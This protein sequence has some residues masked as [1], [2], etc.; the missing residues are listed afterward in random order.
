MLGR[1][2]GVSHTTVEHALKHLEEL[3]VLAPVERGKKRQVNLAKLRKISTMQGRQS[4]RILFLTADPSSNP[5][6]TTRVFY[7]T[8]LELCE[9]EG[10][11]LDYIEIPSKLPEL[12]ALLI[13]LQPR[14]IILCRAAPGIAKV[15]RSLGI[16]AIGL[17]WPFPGIPAFFTDYSTLVIQ[18]FEQA[19]AVGHRRIASP[20][21]NMDPA[22][23]ERVAK[24]MGKHFSEDKGF[25]KRRYNFPSFHGETTEDF[26]AALRELFRYTPPS[27]LIL[28]DLSHYISVVTFLM[29]RRLRVPDDISLIIL[30][31][32]PILDVVRPS[33]AHYSE[34]AGGMGTKAFQLLLEQMDGLLSDEKVEYPPVWVPGESLAPFRG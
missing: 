2:Y 6:Y 17:G 20:C 19:K 30:G 14:G 16:P 4:T 31:H 11:P 29:E 24:Q 1:Q 5:I 32:E 3:G 27:C 23:Y 22:A 21:W 9:G 34:D 8:F 13:S 15:I 33:L 7:Q 12:R 25:F 28:F 18:A 26:Y 10:L